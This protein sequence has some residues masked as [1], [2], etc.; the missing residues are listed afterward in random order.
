MIAL[1]TGGASCGKSALSERLCMDLGRNR[2]YLAAMRPFGKE[3]RDRVRKHRAMRA[4][5]G[6]AT[7][8]CYDDFSAVAHDARIVG[9]TVLLEC[10]GNVMANE[11]F[12]EGSAPGGLDEA[13]AR[14]AAGRVAEAVSSISEQAEHLVIVGNEVGCDGVEY[15]RETRIYQRALGELACAVAGRSDLVV[16]CVA[17]QPVVLK[18]N[19]AGARYAA[20]LDGAWRKAGKAAD[21]RAPNP[22]GGGGQL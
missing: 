19:G 10:L 9:A 11:L 14:Q 22:G 2:V 5:K 4:G 16:E 13:F 15:P 21:F 20:L 3:G 17:G 1:L 8:E 6:F 18:A 7:V 12:S